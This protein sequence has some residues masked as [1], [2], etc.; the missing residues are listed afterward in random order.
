VSGKELQ[1][2]VSLV[3]IHVVSESDG[4]FG[5]ALLAEHVAARL[6]DKEGSVRAHSRGGPSVRGELGRGRG[7]RGG[8]GAREGEARGLKCSQIKDVVL[9]YTVFT[10]NSVHISLKIANILIFQIFLHIWIGHAE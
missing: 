7:G 10:P 4:A 9:F 8:R 6:G 2:R 3:R 1:Q 5:L